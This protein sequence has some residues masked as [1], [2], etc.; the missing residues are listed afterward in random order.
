M[1]FYLFRRRRIEPGRSA[2]TG[3]GL[4]MLAIARGEAQVLLPAAAERTFQGMAHDERFE[5][6]LER[7]A[8]QDP[9][10]YALSVLGFL[11]IDIRPILPNISCP[12]LLI[13]GGQDVLMP[14]D[15]AEVISS[16]VPQA[17]VVR[18]EDVAHFIPFQAPERFVA[19]LRR[20]AAKLVA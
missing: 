15:S 20:F 7:Y 3:A 6:Y 1:V 14:A 9:E 5:R 4:I 8:S 12:V 13:P 19:E 2:I 18:F 11:D 17:E 16:L 10:A